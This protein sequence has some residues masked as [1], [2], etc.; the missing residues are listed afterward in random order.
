VVEGVSWLFYCW[1][2]LEV[3]GGGLKLFEVV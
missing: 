2:W 3:V 1:R